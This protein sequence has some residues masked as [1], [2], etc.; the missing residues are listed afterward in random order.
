M[1]TDELFWIVIGLSFGCFLITCVY[2]QDIA[3]FFFIDWLIMFIVYF[4]YLYYKWQ[5]NKL[6]KKYGYYEPVFG[7]ASWERINEGMYSLVSKHEVP[8]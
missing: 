8:T 7:K 2:I 3:W 5:F 6:S 1:S 4:S